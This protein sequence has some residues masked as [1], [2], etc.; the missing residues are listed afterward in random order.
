MCRAPNFTSAD[1]R[2]TLFQTKCRRSRPRPGWAH[3]RSGRLSAPSA[4]FLQVHML[5]TH[6]TC[7]IASSC[8]YSP[9]HMSPSSAA[10]KGAA[11]GYCAGVAT[12]LLALWAMKLLE[13]EE[14]QVLQVHRERRRVQRHA[15]KS[16]TQSAAATQQ[17]ERKRLQAAG[18]QERAGT[19]APTSSKQAARPST[20]GTTGV[21][22]RTAGLG[23]SRHDGRGGR[24]HGPPA[25]AARKQG[26][27]SRLWM[28]YWWL[29]RLLGIW[30]L[31]ATVLDSAPAAGQYILL[32]SG[33]AEAAAAVLLASPGHRRRRVLGVAV[34]A[35]FSAGFLA[36]GAAPHRVVPA[37]L[38]SAAALRS[39]SARHLGI[40]GS[41][42]AVR[43]RAA[44]LR[45]RILSHR[46]G[47]FSCLVLEKLGL[48]CF[49]ASWLLLTA[50]PEL[51]AFA[52]SLL[53]GRQ[54]QLPALLEDLSKSLLYPNSWTGTCSI[55]PPSPS[56]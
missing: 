15:G 2:R 47:L 19:S 35:S 44:A 9:P 45:S 26:E 4:C 52:A 32:A 40:V 13:E 18:A 16:R 36:V 39:L 49:Y 17:L 22:G 31:T 42:T 53:S 1:P 24:R 6:T 21:P 56:V 5:F 14:Q 46:W 7:M 29:Q 38:A 12:G 23:G 20:A 41:A 50:T 8:G 30:M 28:A 10:L 51:V 54:A 48:L 55:G 34:S 37:L 27:S 3:L 25:A 43:V 11:V 33:A